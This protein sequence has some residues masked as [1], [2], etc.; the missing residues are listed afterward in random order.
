MSY[1]IGIDTGGTFTD[2]IVVDSDGRSRLFK[3][4]TTIQN[5][6]E[7]LPSPQN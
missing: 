7:S 2:L 1:M 5:P 6:T 3:S 4:P